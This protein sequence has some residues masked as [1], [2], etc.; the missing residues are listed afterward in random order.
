MAAA[1]AIATAGFARRN[2]MQ[3]TRRG[4]C[5]STA[6]A[7][8]RILPP[9][10]SIR[11]R[12]TST[13]STMPGKLMALQE[14]GEPFELDPQD[15]ERGAFM[16]TGGKRTAHPKIDPETGEMVWFDYFVGSERFSN[17]IDYGVTDKS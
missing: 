12:R 8:Q 1:P 11:A 6:L 17:L 14:H 4:V 9:P 3:R 2:G 13:S 5:S 16:N 7:H 10:T 15:L